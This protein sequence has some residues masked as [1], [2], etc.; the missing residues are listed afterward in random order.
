VPLRAEQPLGA[1]VVD[2]GE[3][4]DDLDVVTP[5]LQPTVERA[6]YFGYTL[7]DPMEALRFVWPEIPHDVYQPVYDLVTAGKFGGKRFRK[8]DLVRVQHLIHSASRGQ[9]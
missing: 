4:L 3:I 5:W 1:R 9:P 2:A 6:L 8:A 7:V